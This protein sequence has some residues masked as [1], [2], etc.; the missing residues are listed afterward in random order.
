MNTKQSIIAT[1]LA[2]IALSSC[3]DEDF[4]YT[5]REVFNGAFQ[6]NFIENF[7]D[8]DPD[9]TWDLS[10]YGA[11]TRAGTSNYTSVCQTANGTGDAHDVKW[12]EVE[13]GTLNWINKNLPEFTNNK[14]KISSDNSFSFFMKKGQVI[15][16]LPIY[17]GYATM[18]W[19]LHMVAVKANNGSDRDITVYKKNAEYQRGLSYVQKKY[20]CN[21]CKATG[22]ISAL[23]EYTDYCTTNHH[24][25]NSNC[26]GYGFIGCDKNNKYWNA[27]WLTCPYCVAHGF[28]PHLTPCTKCYDDGKMKDNS[29]RTCTF[30][31]GTKRRDCTACY[32]FGGGLYV[33]DHGQPED[34]YSC[35]GKGTDD[36]WCDVKRIEYNDN[37]WLAHYDNHTLDAF[38]VRST[39]VILNG[40]EIPDG[41]EVYF[42]LKITR[43]RD[44]LQGASR[45]IQS[46]KQGQMKLIT[47]TRPTN[48]PEG[49]DCMI[50][51]VEDLD[52]SNASGGSDGGYS[53]WDYND[54]VFLVTGK[55]PEVVRETK[56]VTSTIKKR[57]MIEDLG[58]TFDH[59]FNDLVVDVEQTTT[60]E[61]KLENG[62]ITS[63]NSTVKQ[64]ATVKHMG[65]TFPVQIKVGDYTFG[66]VSNPEDLDLTRKQLNKEEAALKDYT[67][68]PEGKN[69]G[70]D[71]DVTAEITGW[72]PATNNITCY[73]WNINNVENINWDNTES[74]KSAWQVEFPTTAGKVPFIIAVDP[75]TPWTEENKLADLA[76]WRAAH[77]E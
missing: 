49:Y 62:E 72:D 36:N 69:P 23:G 2:C 45:D 51:G 26:S 64:N 54:I 70:I 10:E 55:L 53:D 38:A 21:T 44:N 7:G 30:C 11:I 9:E 16:I 41:T 60:I 33:D 65:G 22:K 52:R 42:Y 48:I 34:C 27:E 19:E 58:S 18:E 35:H 1:C 6:R 61:M 15:E 28:D 46:S 20:P 67:T 17:L 8:I 31:K 4:G 25:D 14:S 56:T 43:N 29:G 59:D 47:P 50:L 57:Y 73:V 63:Q 68:A 71:P 77:Q 12:Y 39:S 66:R 3:Q 32:G 40:N 24:G 37:P 75:T 13:Q 76:A 5:E 74:W